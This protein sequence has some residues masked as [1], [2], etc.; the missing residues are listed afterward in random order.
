M[1]PDYRNIHI[2][3]I[4]DARIKAAGMTYARFARLLCIERTTV[5]NIIRSKSID[6]ERLIRI[7]QILGYDFL[8][9]VYLAEDGGAAGRLH[10]VVN[11]VEIPVDGSGECKISI[12]VSRDAK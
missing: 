11:G 9:N 8:R 3:R 4:I 12:K 6:T 7:G 5:Y 2:G 10:V 1:Y